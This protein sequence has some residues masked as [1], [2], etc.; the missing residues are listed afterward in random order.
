M[1]AEMRM[2]S[3]IHYKGGKSKCRI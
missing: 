3:A 2:L 1:R